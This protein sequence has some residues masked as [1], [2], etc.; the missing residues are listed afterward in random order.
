MTTQ[1]GASTP[2]RAGPD[3]PGTELEAK[4]DTIDKEE[5]RP[6]LPPR[7]PILQDAEAPSAPPSTTNR[8]PTL[9]SQPTTAATNIDIQTLSFPDGSRGT[10]ST[11]ANR[12]VSDSVSVQTGDFATPARKVSRNSSEIDDNASLMSFAPTLRANGDL[13]S[14]LDEGLNSQ[15]PAWRLL[16]SQ[17]D[18]VNPFETIVYEDR[19]LV[20][21][22]HEFD[23]I[24]EADSKKG[25]EG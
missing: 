21:F 13:V 3:G 10:F 16:S 25:N 2:S 24:A 20:N 4:G 1:A 14:L 19:S 22:E 8:H 5:R 15:S 12:S 6:P 17:A 7:P 11:P 23:E 9:Q 18:T